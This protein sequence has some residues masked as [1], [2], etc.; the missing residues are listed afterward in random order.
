MHNQ[1]LITIVA[2]FLGFFLLGVTG[3]AE[4]VAQEY[5]ISGTITAA[6]RGVD[7]VGVAFFNG[8][9][10]QYTWTSGGGHYAYV[11]WAGWTGTITPQDSCYSFTPSSVNVGPVNSNLVQ[12]FLA[13]R[14][15]VQV[16]GVISDGPPAYAG[17]T[18]VNPVVGVQVAYPP[19]GVTT[20]GPDGRYSFPVP[21]GSGVGV[22]TP[23]KAGWSFEPGYIVV[24][25][26]VFEDTNT[27]SFQG[28]ESSTEYTISGRITDPSGRTALNGV[29]MEFYDGISLVST[30]T[31]GD[32]EYSHAFPLGWAGTVAPSM[33]GYTFTPV[34]ATA[35][36][37]TDNEVHNFV[38]DRVQITI[39]GTVMTPQAEP[40]FGVTLTLS[41]G[42]SVVSGSDGGFSIQVPY[43]WSGNLVP[44]LSGWSFNP[45]RRYYSGVVTSQT[46]QH[47]VA[48]EIPQ[49]FTISGTVTR[50]G[51]PLAGVRITGLE[52]EPVTDAGGFY[53]ARV[54]EGW[55]GTV[56][57]VKTGN[58]F[59]PKQRTYTDVAGDLVNQNYSASTNPP[60]VVT[61]LSPTDGGF[62]S[63]L[64]TVEISVSDNTGVDRVELWIDGEKV[65]EFF[66]LSYMAETA[67]SGE[68]ASPPQS[69]IPFERL[70]DLGMRYR[71]VR[72][73]S[74][75]T[76]LD[77]LGVD[78]RVDRLLAARL[79]VLGWSVSPFGVVR[80]LTMHPDSKEKLHWRLRLPADLP[81]GGDPRITMSWP[82]ASAEP[83]SAVFTCLYSWNTAAA[84]PGT[85][86][87]LARAYDI[88]GGMGE[89]QISVGIST[90]EVNLEAERAREYAWIVS[91]EY[92]NLHITVD[93]PESIP[94]ATYQV[95]RRTDN[96]S[97][98]L[99]NE[100]AANTSGSDFTLVDST[101]ESG[102]VYT[103]RVTA[104][105]AEGV[106]IG[107][108]RDVTI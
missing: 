34:Q 9:T 97:F 2:I 90:L 99:I 93:N 17:E 55:D 75:W 11:V 103:Y 71:L 102:H 8:E 101:I 74:G 39:S 81:N 108:S 32:G 20:T 53:S 63:G 30:L 95:S 51:Q 77:R 27:Y 37:L 49:Q 58:V 69:L 46:D 80:A 40:V 78:P 89:S 76:T 98:L 91:R 92:A 19:F 96:G 70:D 13:T 12:D 62:V 60:P 5:T 38:G 57:P 41:T 29:T 10:T 86:S 15:T 25:E 56:A 24:E 43:G 3:T 106:P 64:A 28:T 45:V 6:G 18:L 4:A 65:A 79:Q 88:Q 26:P 82:E 14:Y 44:S 42:A 68:N 16:G 61:F 52:G 66:G 87:L 107:S 94:V 50:D 35:G 21:C 83:S 1:R 7:G 22:I 54:N 23:V 48:R 72:R 59:T 85:H 47:F 73:E 36:P 67:M 104:V 100:V 105:D 31:S 33:P 84:I